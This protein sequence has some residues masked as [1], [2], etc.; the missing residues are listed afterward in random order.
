MNTKFQWSKYNNNPHWNHTTQYLGED[1]H[2]L[3]FRQAQGSHSHRPGLTYNTETPVLFLLDREGNWVAK[4]FPE[5][6][7]DNMLIYIDIATNVTYNPDTHTVTGVDMD[8]DVIKTTTREPWIEDEDE[9]ETHTTLYNYPDTLV[10]T[11]K[12]TA[13][14][15]LEKIQNQEAPFDGKTHLTWGF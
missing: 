9:F 15:L 2:G 10:K 8:L 12:T 13:Q 4:L 1:E 14:T 7:D 6:R 11:A 5:G 3:W